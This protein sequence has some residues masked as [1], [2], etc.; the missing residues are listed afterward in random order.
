MKNISWPQKN[1]YRDANNALGRSNTKGIDIKSDNNSPIVCD[2]MPYCV[3]TSQKTLRNN[4]LKKNNF[5]D[6]I[7]KEDGPGGGGAVAWGCLLYIIFF[8]LIFIHDCT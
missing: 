8:I 4:K 3:T 6:M 7:H 1:S 2:G 5:D